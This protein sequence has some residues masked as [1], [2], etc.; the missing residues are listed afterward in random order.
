M[1]NLI[2][3]GPPGSGKG[4]QAELIMNKLD[5]CHISTGDV[6]RNNIRQKTKL[7]ELASQYMDRGQLVPDNVTID[8]LESELDNYIDPK[9]FIFDGFPRTIPQAEAFNSLLLKKKID[10]SMVISLE[11]SEDELVKR[12]LN[13]G[14]S[15][16]RQDDQNES[17]VRNRIHVYEKQTS[18]LKSYYINQLNDSF[19]S[20]D[21]ESDIEDIFDKIRS[22]IINH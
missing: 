12:L 6:F 20:V 4:T 7:G 8:L 13:R 14:L 19:Y 18:I 11:V 1:I 10:L 22:I 17:V 2:L 3:F 15:S 16:G 9:G 5:L 21:G